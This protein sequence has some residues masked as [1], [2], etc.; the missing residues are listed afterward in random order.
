ME[1]ADSIRRLG[2]ER[3]L[4]VQQPAAPGREQQD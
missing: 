1:P 4:T 2:F 3:A